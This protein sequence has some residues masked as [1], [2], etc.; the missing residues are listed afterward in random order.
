MSVFWLT[1]FEHQVVCGFYTSY[2][3]D[4]DIKNKK[5]AVL[6]EN[7]GIIFFLLFIIFHYK[8]YFL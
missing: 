1:N 7:C 3:G 8:K 4:V 5:S 2:S 6:F